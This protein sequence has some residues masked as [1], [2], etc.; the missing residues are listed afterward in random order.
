[1][2]LIQSVCI[3]GCPFRY[4]ERV[5]TQQPDA[6]ESVISRSLAGLRARADVDIAFGANVHP[7]GRAMRIQHISGGLT[8]ALSGL[9]IASGAGLGGK[10]LALGR[11]AR[12][13][14]YLAARGITHVYDHAV[15]QERLSTVAALPVRVGRSA[16]YV[17]YLGHRSPLHLGDRWLDDL[18]PVLG[19]L[20]RELTIKEELDRRLRALNPPAPA[21]RSALSPGEL[22]EIATELAALAGEVHD[23]GL[24]ERL[25]AL[26]QR[27]ARDRAPSRRD[28]IT[29][30]LAPRELAVLQQIAT[31]CSNAEAARRLGLLPNTVKSYLQSAMRKLGVNNRVQALLAA[32]EAG[33][34]D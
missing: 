5:G 26:H 16:K 15:E 14:D 20:E 31:G 2:K 21:E 12:V 4:R 29:V 17:V 24:R 33:L 13:H 25:E 6:T 18:A 23:D 9:T 30:D 27:V 10:S 28:A 7:D 34:I 8:R 1:M 32:R 11:P 3:C 19:E 22:R